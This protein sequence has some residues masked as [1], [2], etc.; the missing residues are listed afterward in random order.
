MLVDLMGPSQTIKQ[1]SVYDMDGNRFSAGLFSKYLRVELKEMPWYKEVMEKN[2]GGFI[3]GP[4]IDRDLENKSS[5]YAN[6]KYM[7]LLRMYFDNN[8]LLL[9]IIE[10]QQD[11]DV[12]FRRNQ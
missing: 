6:K 10:A 1:L 5:F 11:S 7:S 9:G 2:G 3:Y 8:K 12:I 4:F